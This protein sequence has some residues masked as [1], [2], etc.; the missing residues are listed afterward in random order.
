MQ[1]FV[2]HSPTPW[3]R[4]DYIGDAAETAC[5]AA[6]FTQQITDGQCHGGYCLV[7]SIRD[8]DG[9]DLPGVTTSDCQ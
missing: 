6:V 2:V 1:E 9:N 3:S 8:E 5:M 7:V 4:K